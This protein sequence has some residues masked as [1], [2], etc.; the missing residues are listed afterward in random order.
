MKKTT[1]SSQYEAAVTALRETGLTVE[2]QRSARRQRTIS[3][4]VRADKLVVMLP[5]RLDATAERGWV[6]H[7][8][9][10]TLERRKRAARGRDDAALRERAIRLMKRYFGQVYSITKIQWSTTKSRHGSCTTANGTIRISRALADLPQFVLDY[11][12]VH[13][14]AHLVHPDHSPAFWALTNRY[15]FAERARGFLLAYDRGLLG[16][17]ELLP[18]EPAES[19]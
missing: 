4:S 6:S 17:G 12:I 7:A 2:V 1:T 18:E 11:V 8:I 15:P 16:A 13:E 19:L 9:V 14:C 3:W 5:A 10:H